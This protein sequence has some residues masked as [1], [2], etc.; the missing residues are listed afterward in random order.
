[1]QAWDMLGVHRPI[2]PVVIDV[3]NS[4]IVVEAEGSK[5]SRKKVVLDDIRIRRTE[6]KKETA[7]RAEL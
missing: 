7:R 6:R 1:M 2:M 5:P 3:G 4:K